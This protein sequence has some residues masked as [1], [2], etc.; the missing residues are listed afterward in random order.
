MLYTIT[1]AGEVIVHVNKSEMGQHV[2]T[3]LA[4][5]IAEELEVEWKNMRL[6]YPGFH[7]I[8]HRRQLEHPDHVHGS[9]PGRRGG[10][11]G[12]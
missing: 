3:A 7:R 1:P 12:A 11:L 9:E 6:D 5:E 8:L 4:Q 2:G 10:P